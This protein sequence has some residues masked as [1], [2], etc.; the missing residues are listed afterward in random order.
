[1]KEEEKGMTEDEMVGQH[2]LLNEHAAAA[3][4]LQSEQIL[5]NSE[6]QGILACCNPWDCK[7]SDMT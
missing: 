6:G 7:K 4:S 3:K 1:M 2:H 5:G